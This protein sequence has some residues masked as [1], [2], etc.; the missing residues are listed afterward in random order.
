ME[1]GVQYVTMVTGVIVMLMLLAM[2]LAILLMVLLATCINPLRMLYLSV[3]NTY[4]SDWTDEKYPFIYT[5]FDC[6]GTET[7][8]SF[9]S[10]S[11]TSNIQY[12]SNQKVVKLT[13]AGQYY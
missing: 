9:C 11:L 2:N 5:R 12:C 4:V 3:G 1:H 6:S 10:S 7:R 13:C 8:L